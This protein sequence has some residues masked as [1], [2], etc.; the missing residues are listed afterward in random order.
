MDERGLKK[1]KHIHFNLL[2]GDFTDGQDTVR[3]SPDETRRLIDSCPVLQINSSTAK[4]VDWAALEAVLQ[5]E[6]A[7]AEIIDWAQVEAAV[8]HAVGEQ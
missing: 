7:E 2:D 5:T 3:L 1:T 8:K 4:I 6:F